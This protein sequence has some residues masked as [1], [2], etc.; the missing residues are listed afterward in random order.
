[1]LKCSLAQKLIPAVDRIRDLYTK[2]GMRP[3]RVWL[4]RTRF[5]GHKRGQGVEQV[6]LEQEILPTPLVVDM[7]ALTEVV[8]P[9]GLNEQGVVQ[10][11][12]VSGRYTEELLM[13]VG[14]DGSQVA[15][16]ETAYYEIEFFRRDGAPS[17]RRR[18]V[19]DSV[20]QYNSS[21]FQWMVTLV[22]V[23]ENRARDRSPEG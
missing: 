2:F 11:Q 8:T 20:P 16:N 21:Q 22:S 12:Y 9:V 14:P 7:R 4:V 10:L 13:G 1:L 19:R 6:V 23:L 15:S 3:Y 18:F 17:E 5:A